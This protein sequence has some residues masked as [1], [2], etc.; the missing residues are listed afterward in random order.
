MSTE[1]L[2]KEVRTDVPCPNCKE[3]INLVLCETII[4]PKCG[5]LV[6]VHKHAG[7]EVHLVHGMK[8]KT[9]AKPKKPKIETPEEEVEEIGGDEKDE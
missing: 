7:G 1:T 6:A 4:C 3:E 9:S 2:V 8:G 5:M